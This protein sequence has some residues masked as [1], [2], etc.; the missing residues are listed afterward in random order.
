MKVLKFNESFNVG[1]PEIGDYVICE[2]NGKPDEKELYDFISVNIGIISG[3]REERKHSY[4]VKYDNMIHNLSVYSVDN[5]NYIIPFK[6]SEILYW[7][8]DKSELETILKT[9]KFNL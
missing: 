4:E 9:T 1:E 6:L 8:K 2:S 7:G 5:E 3:I